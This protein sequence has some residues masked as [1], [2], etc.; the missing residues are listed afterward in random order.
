M[1]EEEWPFRRYPPG[2][3]RPGSPSRRDAGE[4]RAAE[5]VR[6]HREQGWQPPSRGRE[7]GLSREE[8]VRAAIAVADAE[9]PDA[10]SMRRIARELRAGAMSL[11]WHVGSK[12]ELID[13]MLDALEAEI[14]I[15]APSGDWRADLRAFAYSQRAGWLRHPWIM[16]FIGDR[17]PSGPNDVRKFEAMLTLV[18]Q[19]G[20]DARLTINLLMTLAMY[21][22]GAVVRET[23]EVRAEQAEKLAEAELSPP[24]REAEQARIH[25]WFNSSGR[26]PNVVRL[27]ESGLDP[28][29]P[30]TRDER[31]EYGLEVVLDGIASRLPGS[32][33]GRPSAS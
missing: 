20:L 12:D 25:A 14:E 19:L 11:Y 27:L 28:D 7:R 8:I 15:P 30:K 29:D 16:D 33:S 22:M 2:Y 17:P 3:G 32:S 6:R 23:Q 21:I 18:G 26:F 9:G 31:F 13:A 10:I 4:R 1:D 24:E 5:L